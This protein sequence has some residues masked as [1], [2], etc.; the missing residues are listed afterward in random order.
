[1]FKE[2]IGSP[3]KVILEILNVRISLAR[4]ISQMQALN[5]WPQFAPSLSLRAGFLPALLRFPI[6]F[7]LQGSGFRVSGFGC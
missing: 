6:G 1:M 4:G 5:S 2:T 7:G 3:F